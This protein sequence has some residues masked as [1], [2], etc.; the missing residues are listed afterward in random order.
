MSRRLVRQAITEAEASLKAAGV[1]EARL[2]A[3]LLVGEVARQGR[4][5]LLA[6]LEHPLAPEQ[7]QRLGAFLAR[8]LKREPLAYILGRKEFYGLEFAVRP[9]VLIPRPE[10]ELLVESVLARIAHIRER[11]VEPRVADIGTGCGNIAIAI[12]VHAPD[13]RIYAVDSSPEALAVARENA[14]RLGVSERVTLLPGDLLSPLPEQVDIVAAN[15]PYVPSGR[16]RSLQPELRWEPVE[17]L[18]GGADGTDVLRR[19]LL[20]SQARLKK[21]GVLL[22]EIDPE[23]RDALTCEV[24]RRFP[25]AR[26]TVEKD[27]A[28]LDRMLVVQAG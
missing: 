26:I 28:G 21:E 11:G 8:R 22:L 4:A 5:A 24:L 25:N 23:Q 10:T 2:E 27:L 9:G 19:L 16:L 12:A 15:L 13:V 18:D 6:H 17:A 20:Q 1:S 7:E 3:E 14:G